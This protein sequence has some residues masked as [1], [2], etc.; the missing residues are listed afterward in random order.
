MSMKQLMAEIS[1]GVFGQVRMDALTGALL[2]INPGHKEIHDGDSFQAHYTVTTAATDDHRTMIGFE[3]AAASEAKKMHMI[4]AVAASQPAEAFLLEGP[5][6][7]DDPGANVAVLNRNRVGT[8]GTAAVCGSLEAVVAL[9]EFTT[10]NEAQVAAATFSGG[11]ELD[12]ILLAG[13]EGPRAFGGSGRGAQEWVLKAATKYV[14]YIQNIG[15]N[16]NIHALNANFYEK[17]PVYS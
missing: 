17:A 16:A 13:G 12:Y 9:N 7:D 4:I 6:I 1:D 10:L 5:T 3:T 11:T 2:T 8:P 14:I 15:A